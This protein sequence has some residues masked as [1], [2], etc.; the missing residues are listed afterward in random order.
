[1]AVAVSIEG[2][3]AMSRAFGRASKEL[4]RELRR[5]I[6]AAAEPVRRDAERL[7]GQEISHMGDGA[8]W[9]QMRL[10]GGT[11]VTY[12]APRQR[13]RS[14]RW[15]PSRRRPNLKDKLLDD[16]MIPALHQNIDEVGRAADRAVDDMARAWVAG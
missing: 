6:Y 14:S 13:G 5:Q 8:P 10:G 16:A 4:Q 9:S 15:D 1:M 11:R 3:A 7:A 12:V 2:L